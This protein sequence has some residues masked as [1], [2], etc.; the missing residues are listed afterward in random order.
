[1]AIVRV[2][3]HIGGVVEVG[4]EEVVVVARHVL[5]HHYGAVVAERVE[6]GIC[7]DP[8]VGTNTLWIALSEVGE[9]M[10]SME[11]VVGTEGAE[12]TSG[13]YPLHIRGV[14]DVGV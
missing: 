7:H 3:L 1:M 5:P 10:N 6:E 11:S 4:R 12:D 2:D 14:G 9:G 13:S 8:D